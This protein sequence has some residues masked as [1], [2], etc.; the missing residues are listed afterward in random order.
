MSKTDYPL[1]KPFFIENKMKALFKLI[2]LTVIMFIFAAC[3]ESYKHFI[4]FYNNAPYDVY[5]HQAFVPIELAS[6]T[7]IKS[8]YLIRGPVKTSERKGISFN[9]PDMDYIYIYV[10][11]E[12]DH[13]TDECIILQRYYVTL[14][15][16]RRLDDISYPPTEAMKNIKMYPPYDQ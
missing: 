15:D 11:I 4:M 1:S 3:P 2:V 9:S 8:Q 6:D 13:N 12:N 14:D 5:V 16:I 10:L 7:I